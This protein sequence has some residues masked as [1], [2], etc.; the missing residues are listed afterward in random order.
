MSLKTGNMKGCSRARHPVQYLI[1]ILERF[2]KIVGVNRKKE[3][4]ILMTIGKADQDDFGD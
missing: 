1:S 3:Q 2:I 4:A